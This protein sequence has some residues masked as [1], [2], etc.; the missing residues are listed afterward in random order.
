MY[1]SVDVRYGDASDPYEAQISSSSVDNKRYASAEAAIAAAKALQAG[2]YVDS[3]D[4]AVVEVN[5]KF[6][7]REVVTQAYKPDDISNREE[8]NSARLVS[9][10]F[11]VKAILADD[12]S[13]R[14][15]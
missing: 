8:L 14:R 12:Q 7:V 1:S 4:Y 3:Y 11:N 2:S 6:E 15:F 9:D 5:G 10:R 13:V